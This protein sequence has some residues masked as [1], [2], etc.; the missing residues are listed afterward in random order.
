DF[1]ISLGE[2]NWA[3]GR[4]NVMCKSPNN[5]PTV[6]D[7]VFDNPFLYFTTNL[8]EFTSVEDLTVLNAEDLKRVR[9]FA[10]ALRGFVFNDN[11]LNEYF[12]QFYWYLPKQELK[13]DA[14][15]LTPKEQD[16]LKKVA[17][18]EKMKKN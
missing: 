11:K 18:A 5:C 9:N 16:F 14:I 13:L 10:Y 2:I 4:H 7:N 15:E 1:D 12:S 6:P 3:F 17:E 8:S